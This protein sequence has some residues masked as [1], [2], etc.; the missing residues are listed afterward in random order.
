MNGFFDMPAIMFSGLFWNPT[1]S[2][3]LLP[4]Y[5]W[6]DVLVPVGQ[7]GTGSQGSLPLTPRNVKMLFYL[8]HGTQLNNCIQDVFGGDGANVPQQTLQNA[9]ILNANYTQAELSA[10]AGTGSVAW[11]A[12]NLGPN[13]TVFVASDTIY[14]SGG[15]NGLN[16]IFGSFAHELGNILDEK[17]NPP[18]TTGQP[19]GRTYGDP[20]DPNDTDTGAQLEECVFGSLQ[21]P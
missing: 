7:G 6:G 10:A 17:M 13:G 21:Y 11:N 12:P 8:I 14:H 19:Y 18:G 1:D 5:Y 20:N 15:T 3:A 16:A 9:P 4:L 2:N